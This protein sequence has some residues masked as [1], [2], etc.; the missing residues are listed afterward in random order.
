M[1]RN[2]TLNFGLRFEWENG[3]KEQQDRAM[4]WFDPNAAGVDRGRGRGRL[5]GQS[6]TP[7]TAGQPVQRQGRHRLRGQLRD[8]AIAPG[9][10]RRS[11]CR[12]FRSATSWA[13]RNV[14]KGGYGVYYDTLN[15]R[16]WTPNQDGY[17]VTTTNP[18]SNDFGQ[19][20][21]LGDPKNGILPLA[22]PFPVR[23]NRQPIRARSRERARRPTTCWASGIHG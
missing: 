21:A 1:N 11:G 14:I 16:D 3:I 8:T 6:V 4:L 2:L 13:D 7:G 15:A 17:N 18:L 23:A 20:F 10:P 22:D 5:R 19:T 12:G 9:S